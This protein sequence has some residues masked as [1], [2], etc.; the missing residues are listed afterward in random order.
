[1]LEWVFRRCDG[2]AE[3]AETPIGRVPTPDAIDTEGL[4]VSSEDLDEGAARP[5]EGGRASCRRSLTYATFGDRLP[6]PL[7]DELSALEER[8]G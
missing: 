4:D 5:P 3:A 1:M 2:D 8:L 6:Q 7:R